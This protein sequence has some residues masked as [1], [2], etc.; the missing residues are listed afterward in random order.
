MGD[1]AEAV[2]IWQKAL[3]LDNVTK[4]DEARKEAIKKKMADE[5][6]ANP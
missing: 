4:R 3:D 5:S 6:G 1:K 2:A